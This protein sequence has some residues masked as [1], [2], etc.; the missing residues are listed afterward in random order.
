MGLFKNIKDQALKNANL[1]KLKERAMKKAS[2][3]VDK[4][5][6]KM[7]E[8]KSN[9]ETSE[10]KTVADI[11]PSN[12]SVHQMFSKEMEA[13]IEAT[14]QD[15]VI[16]DQEKAVLIKRAQKEGIDIDELDVYI[17]SLLQKRHQAAAEEEARKDRQSKF[18]TIKKCPNCGQQVQIGWAACPMCGFAFNVEQNSTAYTQFVDKLATMDATM[19]TIGTFTG[20]WAKRI[21]KKADFIETYPVPNNRLALLEFLTQLEICSNINASPPDRVSAINENKRFELS[22]W[23]LFEKCIII[24]KRSFSNDPDFQEFF[25]YYNQEVANKKTGLFSR[26][27]GK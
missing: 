18:G 27:L 17:Q 23:I 2:E 14:L 16:T 13:L 12:E 7:S 26:L 8:I 21:R 15:G 25:T 19:S 24:A 10:K 6:E 22:Y 5:Q 11:K 1:D 4:A 3:F 9:D 20:G